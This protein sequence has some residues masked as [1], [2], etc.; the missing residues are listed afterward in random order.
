MECNPAGIRQ[1]EVESLPVRRRRIPGTPPKCSLCCPMCNIRT[2]NSH[3]SLSFIELA[4]ILKLM[5]WLLDKP[6]TLV[7]IA[8][9]V[10]MSVEQTH[11]WSCAA[12]V[13]YDAS[14]LS[15]CCNC[16]GHRGRQL[17]I[18]GLTSPRHSARSTRLDEEANFARSGNIARY[19]LLLLLIFC[20]IRETAAGVQTLGLWLRAGPDEGPSVPR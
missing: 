9:F 18:R 10:G 20:C 2:H 7:D 17:D 11:D 12:F 19:Q 14:S 6:V 16:S 1:G 13:P 3:R 4:N 8:A 15:P 5:E